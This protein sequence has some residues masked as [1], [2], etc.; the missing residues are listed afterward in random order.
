M[1]TIF[2]FNIT[3]TFRILKCPLPPF[4]MCFFVWAKRELCQG[5]F[6]DHKSPLI[7]FNK[8]C[9]LVRHSIMR[10]KKRKVRAWKQSG[11]LHLTPPG[12][13]GSQIS[14]GLSIV[15]GVQLST[16]DWLPSS[17]KPCCSTLLSRT[18]WHEVLRGHPILTSPNEE[19]EILLVSGC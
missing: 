11:H 19:P 18:T 6:I 7:F 9:Y 5:Y 8:K 12:K 10:E 13:C 17:C 3:W 2:F 15:M 16:D 4:S 14:T 1:K